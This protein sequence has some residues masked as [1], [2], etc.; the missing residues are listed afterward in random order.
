[1]T[2]YLPWHY[3]TGLLAV[4]RIWWNFLEFTYHYFSIPLLVRTLF[5]PF[6]RTYRVKHIPGFSFQDL[7]DR[8]TFNT[9]SRVIGAVVRMS[10]IIC[11]VFSL[12]VVALLGGIG[13]VLWVILPGLT[14][15]FYL[16]ARSGYSR[17]TPKDFEQLPELVTRLLQ[18]PWGKFFLFRTGIPGKDII[19]NAVPDSIVVPP[20]AVEGVQNAFLTVF[21]RS[22]QLQGYFFNRGMTREDILWVSQW[23]DRV[24]L[25]IQKKRAFWQRDYLLHIPSIGKTWNYGYTPTLDAYVSDLSEDLLPFN[26]FYGRT[27]EI[28]TIEHILCQRSG[29]NLLLVGD[30]GVGKHT[31]LTYL[32]RLIKEGR[33]YPA[34]EGKRL[35]FCHLER[36]FSAERDAI[37]RK[38][39]LTSVLDEAVMAGNVILVIDEF[40][41]F[42]SAGQDRIDLSDVFFHHLQ[43]NRMQMVALMSPDAYQRYVKPNTTLGNLFGLVELEPI[44]RDK[45]MEILSAVT[46]TFEQKSI[47]FLY[48][49]LRDV[50][51][52]ADQ[53]IKEIPFPVKAITAVDEIVTYQSNIERTGPITSADVHAYFERKT[54]IPMHVTQDEKKLLLTLEDTFKK[55]IIGQDTAVTRLA[56]ALRRVRANISVNKNRPMGTF[57]FLGPTGVGKTET[58][59]VLARTYFG[60]DDALVRFD[61]AQFRDAASVRQFI[62]DFES[63]KVGVFVQKLHEHPYAVVL[64]D[65]FEKAHEDIMNLFLSVF[66]EG[67]ITDAFGKKVYLTNTIVIATSNAAGEFI[68]ERISTQKSEDHSVLEKEVIETVQRE[69]IFSP[70][71]INRFDAVVVYRPLT[72]PDIER[73]FDISVDPILEKLYKEKGLSV[74]ILPETKAHVIAEGFDTAFGGRALRRAVEKLV[75]DPIAQKILSLPATRG[76]KIEI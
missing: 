14:L 20:A 70:E 26:R 31:L 37:Q 40:D 13:I 24:V 49:A 39:T 54:H 2:P 48:E 71:L 67:Y 3:R 66:D 23:Y 75:E 51:A 76:Q 55:Q 52:D 43:S 11:G 65:E 4:I 28:E 74:T 21:D 6:K 42:I 57:L 38:S 61:M 35:L 7:F 10:V 53:F 60:S 25:E 56:Q 8:L 33:V 12:V 73:I 19:T 44:N 30:P 34:I 5:S 29:N 69:G 22:P 36:L 27:Q 63:G 45:T 17:Y 64:L 50:V 62:G 18:T 72:A 47:Y 41:R 32:A 9:V 59:K 16:Q 58:A 1:M 46:P 68:R 15:P